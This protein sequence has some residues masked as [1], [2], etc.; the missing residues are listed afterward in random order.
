MRAYI[1]QA[2]LICEEC[3][4]R[5]RTNLR[6]CMHAGFNEED[7]SSYDSD[8]FPKGPYENGGG[9]A[10]SPQ[11]CDQCHLFLENPLTREGRE[12]AELQVLE[13]EQYG[14]GDFNVLSTWIDF[15]SIPYK[16]NKRS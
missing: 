1:F 2:A 6:P 8:A 10:D 13:F 9:E 4:T 12:Y 5:E 16:G 7:E 14:F 11:H 15:Y 3:A